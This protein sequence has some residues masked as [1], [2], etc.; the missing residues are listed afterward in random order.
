MTAKASAEDA[1]GLPH[2]A[3]ATPRREAANAAKEGG[4]LGFHAV[5]VSEGEQRMLDKLEEVLGSTA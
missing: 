1:D 5:R 2:V 4:F 3:L